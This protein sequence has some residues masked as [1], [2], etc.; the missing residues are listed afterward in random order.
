[1]STGDTL[2][3]TGLEQILA[4]SLRSLAEAFCRVTALRLD[5]GEPPFPG[6]EQLRPIEWERIAVVAQIEDA[7]R[8][9]LEGLDQLE[10]L[11]RRI[12]LS[13]LQ[14]QL[15]LPLPTRPET[16]DPGFPF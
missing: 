14:A 5:F 4:P 16:A 2:P 8:R 10:E 11:E 6:E 1:M 15:E 3:V 7:V 13:V 9:L 12:E